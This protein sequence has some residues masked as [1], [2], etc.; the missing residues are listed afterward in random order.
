LQVEGRSDEVET[1]GG[2]GEQLGVSGH[3]GI[4]AGEG[5]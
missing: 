5:L 3:G 4:I 2:K 1:A